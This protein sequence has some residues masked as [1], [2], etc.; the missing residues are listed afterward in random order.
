[1]YGI[2]PGAATD[3]ARAELEFQERLHGWVL[4]QMVLRARR[5]PRAQGGVW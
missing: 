4:G 2:G 1:V 3:A 5:R